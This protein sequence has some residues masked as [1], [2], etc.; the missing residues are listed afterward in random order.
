MTLIHMEA[1]AVQQTTEVET[2]SGNAYIKLAAELR[3]ELLP[4]VPH[5]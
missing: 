2:A 3:Q 1:S 5:L 4:Y